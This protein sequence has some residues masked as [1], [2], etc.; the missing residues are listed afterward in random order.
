M[1]KETPEEDWWQHQCLPEQFV[2]MLN[3]L[4]YY[5]QGKVLPDYFD[6]RINLLKDVSPSACDSLVSFIT[7]RIGKEKL[8]TL[9]VREYRVWSTRLTSIEYDVL[10][11]K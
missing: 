1:L 2:D 9:L 8:H 11:G 10:I 4:I 7:N 6:A 5:L 3:Q